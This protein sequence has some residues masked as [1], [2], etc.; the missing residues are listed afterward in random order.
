[1][2]DVEA[3]RAVLQARLDS[4]KVRLESAERALERANTLPFW[5]P[6]NT[7]VGDGPA[8]AMAATGPLSCFSV[9]GEIVIS[10]QSSMKDAP[11]TLAARPAED[12]SMTR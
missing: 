10:G 5:A 4:A 2:R 6:I 1:V 9:P 3:Q 8:A 12:G 7:L 11:T